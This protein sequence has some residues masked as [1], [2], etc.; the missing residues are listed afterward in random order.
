[1][2]TRREALRRGARLLSKKGL[3]NALLDAEVLLRHLL[4][5]SRTEL[6]R[7][8]DKA[9]PAFL[10]AAYQDLLARRA[11]GVPLQYL[12][13]TREFMG[14]DLVVTPAVL[15]PRPETEI[16]VETAVDL[17]GREG[18]PVTILDLGTGSGAIAV[19]LAKFIPG[20]RLHAVDISAAAL[21]VAWENA[22]RHQVSGRITFYCGDLFAP[23]AASR[24]Q[25]Q[26]DMIVSNPPYIP[27]GDLATL[28]REVRDFEP[29]HA[30]DGGPDGLDFYRRIAAG[31]PEFLRPGGWL[32]VEVGK[33]QAQAV[34]ETLSATAHFTSFC[35]VPDLAG[36]P[37]VV[38]GRGRRNARGRGE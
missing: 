1:M 18:K 22:R 17:L 11:A 29:V 7:D 19:S 35:T 12:T 16:L 13:G 25:G 3:S 32:L 37:R 36:I 4:G 14:L 27:T 10:F 21:A 6:Y 38:L 5:E 24:L 8:L 30:L 20:A 23:L 2:V 31:A 34:V 15:I 9:I 28:P 33:D 26:V